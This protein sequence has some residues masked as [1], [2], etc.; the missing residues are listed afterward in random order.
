ML[1]MG[2]L[3]WIVVGF[4]AGALSGAVVGDRTARGCL[5]NIVIGVIGGIL[6]GF[7]ATQLGFDQTRGFIAAVIVAFVGAVVVRL[8]LRALDGGDRR[9]Y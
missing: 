3:G 7:I 1:E 9:R 4:L 6:G 8:I 5:P 2:L